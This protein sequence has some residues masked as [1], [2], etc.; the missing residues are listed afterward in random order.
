MI[1]ELRSHIIFCFPSWKG[2]KK[3]KMDA[4]AEFESRLPQHLRSFPGFEKPGGRA[5][6]PGQPPI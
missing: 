4:I 6:L 5:G 3:E 2:C 1:C